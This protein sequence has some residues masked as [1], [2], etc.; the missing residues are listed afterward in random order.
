L[1]HKPTY[2]LYRALVDAAPDALIVIDAG[3]VIRIANRQAE[4]LF[5]YTPADL[6]GRS[7]D[8]LVPD[9]I[10]GIHPSHRERYV[11]HPQTRPMGADLKLTA[12]RRDGSTFPVD[13]SLSSIDTADGLLVSAAV[14]DISERVALEAKFEG[15]LDAAPDAIIAV[16]AAGRIRLVNRQAESLFGYDRSELIGTA[17]ERLVPERVRGHHPG[18]R[19]TYVKDARPRPMGEGLTLSAV[20]KDGTEFPVDIALSSI[21]T[22]D[23]LLVSA[24]I[25][26]ITSRIAAE[27]ERQLIADELHEARLRQAQRLESVGQLAGGIA[28]DFNNLL[29]VILNYADFLADQLPVGEMRQDLEE[30]QRAATRAADLTRQLLIFARREVVKLEL[31]DLNAVVTGVEKLL[32]RTIGENVEFVTALAPGLSAVRADPGQLEQVFLNLAVNARDAMPGG[33]RL[34]VETADVTLDDAYIDAHPGPAPGRYVRLTVSD[35]GTGMS[36]ATVA[37]AFEPFF[38]TKPA[39]QG[40]GLGLAT[41]YGIVTQA[42]G[43]VRIH[44]EP[45][46]GTAVSIHLPAVGEAVPVSA[47]S[48]DTGLPRGLGQT[49]LVVEDEPAV[50]LAAMRILSTN[51][52]VVL[53]HATPDEAVDA[54]ADSAKRIDLLLTDVVMPG[55]SGVELANR[56][57]AL[58]AGLRVVYMSGYSHEVISHQGAIPAGSPL[59]QKPFMRRELLT[60]LHQ[61]L[62]SGQE[63]GS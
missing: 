1:S 58:R 49:V 42:G 4:T 54:L 55:M 47:H 31:L 26:D 2:D 16:D 38:T 9:S 44:S 20:R 57:R 3:G 39:G 13:I 52:Y 7:I 32:R 6:I 43:D 60:V 19:N 8:I 59:I 41:V 35:T 17:L 5:G 61:A 18:H 27:R 40:T 33:G 45:N 62:V 53:A 10:R 46:R 21:L 56:A 12:R 24:A 34:V 37:R 14:R 15:L 29:A 30:I 50:L 48:A 23:G 36:Q 28:H 51:G 11:A 22:T 25:R 63:R